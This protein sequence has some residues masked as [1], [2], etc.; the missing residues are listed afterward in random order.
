[1]KLLL[2]SAL[3]TILN[4]MTRRFILVIA[5]SAVSGIRGYGVPVYA[6]DPFWYIIASFLGPVIAF[7]VIGLM[8]HEIGKSLNVSVHFGYLVACSAVYVL[9][10]YIFGGSEPC[11]EFILIGT[12]VVFAAYV[13]LTSVI[14]FAK[15][16]RLSYTK[17]QTGADSYIRQHY[18]GK[19]PDSEIRKMKIR[20][21]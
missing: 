5:S 3:F 11:R 16:D 10:S 7:A 4:L 18:S 17:E 1:M 20:R 12:G 21:L 15:R 8:F 19:I 2:K 6:L 13:V 14:I 9:L